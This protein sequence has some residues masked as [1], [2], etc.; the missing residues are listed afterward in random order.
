MLR[1]RPFINAPRSLMERE[2]S[3]TRSIED[4]NPRDVRSRQVDRHEEKR[5]STRGDLSKD[6]EV[7]DRSGSSATERPASPTQNGRK[8]DAEN[9]EQA[10]R[11]ARTTIT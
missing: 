11:I 10:V 8:R 6:H 2:P 4:S 9:S 1:I 7:A 3:E 5:Y